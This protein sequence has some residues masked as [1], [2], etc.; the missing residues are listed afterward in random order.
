MLLCLIVILALFEKAKKK[1]SA[2]LF[3]ALRLFSFYSQLLI[4]IAPL[5]LS[6]VFIKA[7]ICRDDDPLKGDVACYTGVQL[8]NMVVGIIGLITL[9]VFAFLSQLFIIDMNPSSIVPFSCPQSNVAMLK[10]LAK[11]VL[12]IYVTIDYDVSEEKD[13]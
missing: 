8:A 2:V 6:Q 13:I 1:S 11:L 12:P 7:I 5:P 3:Y 4:T 10:L 9:V